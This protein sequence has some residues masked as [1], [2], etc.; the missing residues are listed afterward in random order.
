MVGYVLLIVFAVVM[1]AIVFA[2]LK[3][4]VPAEALNCPDGSSVFVNEATFDNSTSILNLSLRNNGRFDIAGYFIHI[5]N[6][7][8]EE[9]PTIDLSP[10]LNESFSGKKFG[11]SVIFGQGENLF[12]TGDQKRNIFDIP[13]EI[14]EPY[15]IRI[16]PTRFQEIDNRQRFVSCSDAKVQGLVGEPFAECV[17]EDISVTCGTWVCGNRA[18]NCGNLVS[19]PPDNC[20][21][22]GQVCNSTGSCVLPIQ[23]TDNCTTSG[24]ECGTQTICGNS[25]NCGTCQSGFE[26]DVAGQCNPLPACG[27]GI[28]ETGEQC[29][30]GNTNNF[31]G[32]SS[33]CSIETGWTCINNPS[34]PP[35]SSC[36]YSGGAPSCTNYCLSLGLGYTNSNCPANPGQCTSQNGNPQT[37]GNQECTN[38]GATGNYV[39]CCKPAVP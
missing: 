12:K 8:G 35:A 38:T 3:T 9:L 34:P 37:G 32:C 30:D 14:G 36:A 2:W 22:F 29:D 25:E 5:S 23:C 16:I 24:Y 20:E 6:S 17:P 18:N 33:S 26:C 10:Y 1:G 15:S 19:C 21:S 4:Y 7:S 28:L 31:D 39:C 11:N 27:N 13:P